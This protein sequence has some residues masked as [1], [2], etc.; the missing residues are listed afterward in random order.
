MNTICFDHKEVPVFVVDERT[1][2][3]KKVWVT[4]AIDHSTR[5]AFRP[6][7]TE[8]EAV[9]GDPNIVAMIAGVLIGEEVDGTAVGG[10]FDNVVSDN[11]LA[12]L[13]PPLSAFRMERKLRAH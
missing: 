9:K 11:A 3:P 2:K 5:Y 7:I 12:A 4:V 6:V 13:R 10:R 8:G 1:G